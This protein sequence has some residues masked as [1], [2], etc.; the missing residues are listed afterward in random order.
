MSG[1]FI[2]RSKTK[3][4]QFLKQIILFM[5]LLLFKKTQRDVIIKSLTCNTRKRRRIIDIPEIPAVLDYVTD[6][7][8]GWRDIITFLGFDKD[9]LCARFE[10]ERYKNDVLLTLNLNIPSYGQFC[11]KEIATEMFKHE[12][13]HNG[14]CGN[15]KLKLFSLQPMRRWRVRFNG[16]LN[17]INNNRK[18]VHATISL[19]WQCLSDP[20]DYFASSS[21]WSL[22]RRLACL[23]L[24]DLYTAGF[25]KTVWYLQWGELRGSIHIDGCKAV[26]IRLKSMRERMFKPPDVFQ[27]RSVYSQYLVIEESGHAFANNVVNFKNES[28]MCFGFMTFPIG[29]SHPAEVQRPQP[30]H[31]ISNLLDFPVTLVS[32]KMSYQI[33]EQ[34]KM[35]CYDNETSQFKY[36]TFIVNDKCAYGIE[37]V[38][39]TSILNRSERLRSIDNTTVIDYMDTK[40]AV[41][42]NNLDQANE[43]DYR[44]T[45]AAAL[46]TDL[47]QTAC[48]ERNLVGG[49]ACQLSILRSSEQIIVP[50]GLCLTV[51]AFRKHVNGSD[52]LNNAVN[53]ISRCLQIEG[54]NNLKQMCD[55]AVKLFEKVKISD[56]LNLA[57]ENRL[58]IVFGP[59]AWANKKFAI[60]S[61]GLSEDGTEFSSAGQMATLLNIQGFENVIDAIKVCWGSSVAY[62]VVDYRRQNGQELIESVGV[63]IQEMVDA[64]VAGALFTNDPLTGDDSKMIINACF[65]LG[66]TTVSGRVVPDT[67]TVKRHGSTI[68][69]IE[70][71]QIRDQTTIFTTDKRNG[72]ALEPGSDLQKKQFCLDEK[73]IIRIC[74]QGLKIEDK[75]GTAQDIEW[76]LSKG[77]FYILQARPITSLNM[78]TDEEI[79]HE[80]DS[81]IVNDNLLITTANIQEMMPG[82]VS[83]LTAD[84]FV[85]ACDRAIKYLYCDPLGIKFPVHCTTGIFTVSGSP[86]VNLTSAAATAINGI[87]GERSKSNVEIFIVGQSVSEHTLDTIRSYYGRSVPFWQRVK[88]MF[89][90]LLVNRSEYSKLFTH[91]EKTADTFSIGERSKTASALYDCI[92]ENLIHYYEMWRAYLYKTSESSLWSGFIMAML[93]GTSKDMTIENLADLALLLSQCNDVYS[94]EV[95]TTLNSLAKLIAV[96]DIKD[97][98]MSL[99]TRECDAFLR[100]SKH[101][102]IKSEYDRFM[103]RQGHRGVRE[104]EFLEKAWSQ[105]PSNL[106]GTLKMIIKQG[107]FL[108]KDKSNKT[109]DDILD[110]LKTPISWT[111]KMFLKR[112]LIENAKMGVRSRELGKSVCVKFSNI[113]KE[114]YWRLAKFMVQ[115]SRLPD[116]KLLF[117]LTHAEIGELIEQRSANLVRLAKRRMKV[118][119]KMNEITFQKINIGLPKQICQVGNA[120][121]FVGATLRGMP[122]CRGKANGRACVIKS[123]KDAFQIQEGDILVCRYTDVGW[124]PYFPLINGLVTELGGLLSHGAVVA[125][126]CGIPCLVNTPYATDL[127]K[128]GDTVELDGTEGTLRKQLQ[129]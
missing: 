58:E 16:S 2:G 53:S 12:S 71:T 123:Q 117:F 20:F 25:N 99:P 89:L 127:I 26:N 94:A 1:R 49:K 116:P 62:Q 31:K 111:K 74:Q 120:L 92:D 84:V 121:E 112:F 77:T 72:M 56:E 32:C 34:L 85:G 4:F 24:R 79:L 63:I 3:M 87:A 19:Y 124:S 36:K 107:N 50:R 7:P 5:Y 22:S 76:A 38:D 64:D 104:V 15:G 47:D 95:P 9:G 97:E 75:F 98:F 30:Y 65:G 29:D 6:L 96:S 113:F 91:F 59:R 125:R 52:K 10:A 44:D 35:V 61:S 73:Q 13:L 55:T 129:T 81:P 46:I 67:F 115:E 28:K 88:S 60:R 43:A 83:S 86:L 80:F 66:E 37:R 48:R 14:L 8:Q 101:N 54:F 68:L 102:D 11:F 23:A 39:R 103:K 33:V 42:I 93:K 110:S 69:E 82:A 122:V 105:D 78:V 126:E 114:A 109:I 100:T 70:K 57:I 21:C 41:L 90:K 45:E 17:H 40:T 27:I 108:R 118:Y 51:N 18:R 106:M 128:T 119:P